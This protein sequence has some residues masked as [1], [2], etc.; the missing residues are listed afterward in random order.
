MKKGRKNLGVVL[1]SFLVLFLLGGV[2]SVRAE[3]ETVEIEEIEQ[4]A[5]RVYFHTPYNPEEGEYYYANCEKN[6]QESPSVITKSYPVELT[7]KE[8][9]TYTCQMGITYSEDGGDIEKNTIQKKTIKIDSL[10][11]DSGKE[12][13]PQLVSERGKYVRLKIGESFLMKQFYNGVFNFEPPLQGVK[14]DQLKCERISYPISGQKC[15][16]LKAGTNTNS[17]IFFEAS[18][19]K[20]KKK[21]NS[22]VVQ[23]LDE[24]RIQAPTDLRVADS[25]G[26]NLSLNWTVAPNSAYVAIGYFEGN[27]EINKREFESLATVS[28]FSMLHGVSDGVARV[29]VPE[30]FSDKTYT[31]GVKVRSKDGDTSEWSNLY[32]Y[33]PSS[34]KIVLQ[35]PTDLQVSDYPKLKWTSPTNAKY[36]SAYFYTGELS[37]AEFKKKFPST[38]TSFWPISQADSDEWAREHNYSNGPIHTIGIRLKDD[39]GNIS[40]WSNIIVNKFNNTGGAAIPNLYI[41]K[42]EVFSS[43]E[44][45]IKHYWYGE[46]GITKKALILE[47]KIKNTG[48]HLEIAYEDP[49]NKD[50]ENANFVSVSCGDM[51][52]PI[53]QEFEGRSD[54][55]SM[56]ANATRKEKVF[57]AMDLDN[58]SLAEKSSLSCSINVSPGS[59]NTQVFL[60]RVYTFDLVKNANKWEVKN[61][62]LHYNPTET[63]HF[64]NKIKTLKPAM[65]FG[66]K[67]TEIL[68][69]SSDFY[70]KKNYV[71]DDSSGEKKYDYCVR[72]SDNLLFKYTTGN[73]GFHVYCP[74]GCQDGKCLKNDTE[75]PPASFDDPVLEDY[76]KYSNPF[77]DT[78][79]N[80]IQGRAAA[81]LWRRGI[82]KGFEDGSFGGSFT[83]KRAEVATF[84]LIAKFGKVEDVSIDYVK[85]IQATGNLLDILGE[86]GELV[87]YTKYIVK[88]WQLKIMSGYKDESRNPTGKFG[89]LDNVTAGGFITMFFNTFK[90][91][92]GELDPNYQTSYTDV[93][94]GVYYEKYLQIAERNS[95]D[96][97][98]LKRNKTNHFSGNINL[99][100]YETAVAFYQFFRNRDEI[101]IFSFL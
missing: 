12:F 82:S 18:D 43:E 37:S 73:N 89:P 52:N 33:E 63:E 6:T 39:K 9:G 58:H 31:I 61:L 62:K 50:E 95:L 90:E 72:G 8:T 3:N 20:S 45:E 76:S 99:T 36:F 2:Q 7:L 92:L 51:V 26:E 94:E 85:K 48:G 41:E 98:P 64:V 11:F 87:W 17:E 100:R 84:L 71:E 54:P 16:A 49:Y 27:E 67:R 23:V 88:A 97:F 5:E 81:E 78:N 83:L 13:T 28:E 74:S 69:R 10:E 65:N 91:Y 77:P 56:K 34:D 44:K 55:I 59:T 68:K 4:I 1:V 38:P 30:L 101:N 80:T 60:S 57:L 53:T 66:F 75:L 70:Y 42:L 14:T 40:G 96:L 93:P 22:I 47:A 25:V 15:T 86:D 29:L 19:L 46:N 32:F 24:A 35:A 21:S 79:L